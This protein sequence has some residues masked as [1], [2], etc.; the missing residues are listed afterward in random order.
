MGTVGQNLHMIPLLTF[1]VLVTSSDESAQW[2]GGVFLEDA[3]T[4]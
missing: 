1:L 2:V 4:A 3:T